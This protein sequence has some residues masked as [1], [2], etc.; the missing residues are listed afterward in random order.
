MK[1]KLCKVT[2]KAIGPNKIPYIVT[3]DSR[4]IR[5]PHPNI[6]VHD[7]IKYDIEN[8]KVLDTVTYDMG[9][10]AYVFSGNNIGR[11][12]IILHKETHLNSHDIVHIKDEMGKTFATREENIIM[13]GKGSKPMISL[14][15]DRG[16]YLNILEEA[17]KKNNGGVLPEKKK[18]SMRK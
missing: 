17:E 15:K 18:S 13:I 7:T 14:T 8:K 2:Q 3:S 4:T 10:L 1:Y 11:V 12:G 16:I 6:N 5:F 9:N